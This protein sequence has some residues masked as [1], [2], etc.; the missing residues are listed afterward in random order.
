MTNYYLHTGYI[1]FKLKLLP[2]T[3]DGLIFGLSN[4][5][6]IETDIRLT[7]D[8]DL[9][10][11]HDPVLANGEMIRELTLEQL[12]SRGIPSLLDFLS[13]EK[14]PGLMSKGRVMWIEFKSDCRRGWPVK[15]QISDILYSKF[16]KIIDQ[17][18]I[19]PSNIKVLSF[20]KELL[21]PAVKDER[22]QVYPITPYVNECNKK[23]IYPGGLA[24]ILMRSLKWHM[25][26]AVT[27]NYNG[28]LFAKQYLLGIFSLRHPKYEKIVEL[29][30]ET[31]IELGT[32]LGNIDLETDYNRLHRFSDETEKY[33]RHAKKGEG[34]IIAHRGTGIK[35][36][37]I[38][39]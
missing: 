8:E 14:M 7:K 11:Y 37:D 15:A 25:K 30:D 34:L 33:P 39:E 29:M 16:V 35:G 38:A 12:R 13:H 36:L 19:S 32:N 10:L 23:L 9:V 20:Y 5:D 3:I 27:E 1:Q 4:F 26:N 21:A 24:R 18:D 22:F 31:G 28:L 6:G 17:A 2:N